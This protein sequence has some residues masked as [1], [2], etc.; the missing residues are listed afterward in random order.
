M[1]ELAL[2]GVEG[3]VEGRGDH[4]LDADETGVGGRGVVD[5][6]LADVWKGGALVSRSAAARGDAGAFTFVEMGAV[7]ISFYA[8][9]GV[10]GV[11][12]EGVEVGADLFDWGEV[13]YQCDT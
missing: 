7:V 11:D 8:P 12:V 9:V 3:F 2:L 1:P 10:R 6:A 4:I 13:L 5:E